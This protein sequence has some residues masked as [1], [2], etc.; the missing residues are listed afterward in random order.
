MSPEEKVLLYSSLS[1]VSFFIIIIGAVWIYRY[2]WLD[3][4]KR[5]FQDKTMMTVTV[6]SIISSVV[7]YILAMTKI[8]KIK[9]NSSYKKSIFFLVITS[10][11][12]AFVII[13]IFSPRIRS[14]LWPL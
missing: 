13:L 4:D 1:F 3:D 8:N 14:V 2:T 5:N 11:V 12:Y 7:F 9:K 6:L 10:I